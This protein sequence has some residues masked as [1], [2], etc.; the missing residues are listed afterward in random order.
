MDA[1]TRP[2]HEQ[3]HRYVNA[4]P[5]WGAQAR[6]I[7]V[8]PVYQGGRIGPSYILDMDTGARWEGVD[9][10]I[11]RHVFDTE[12]RE[13]ILEIHVGPAA[14]PPL[15]PGVYRFSQDQVHIFWYHDPREYAEAVG[16]PP[17]LSGCRLAND[18]GPGLNHQ[19]Q[20]LRACANSSNGSLYP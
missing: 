2:T 9:K 19:Y 7:C 5:T 12:Q 16:H 10:I 20:R 4:E 6:I 13:G 18:Y 17:P 15:L 11:E 1:T 14:Q 8:I 3:A